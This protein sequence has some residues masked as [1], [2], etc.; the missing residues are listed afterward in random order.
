MGLIHFQ[1]GEEGGGIEI[2]RSWWIY[3]TIT[4]PMTFGTYMAFNIIRQRSEKGKP[5]RVTV[6]HAAELV[7][8]KSAEKA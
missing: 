6:V 3:F 4:I 7:E 2:S 5:E 8:D 1:T